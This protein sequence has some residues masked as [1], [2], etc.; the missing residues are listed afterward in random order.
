VTQAR[1]QLAALERQAARLEQAK[2]LVSELR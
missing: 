2:V 1:E